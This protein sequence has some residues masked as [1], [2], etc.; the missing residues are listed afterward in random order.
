MTMSMNESHDVSGS[1]EKWTTIIRPNYGFFD[2]RI[3]ELISYRDLIYL[4]VKRDFVTKYK[5]TVLGPLWY[6]VQ[7]LISTVLFAFVFGSIA[8]IST[9]GIPYVLFYY[10][11]TM[12]W[13][14]FESCFKDASDTF[15]TN[16]SLFGKV[17]FPRLTV[18]ISRVFI[19]M[20]ALGIQFAFLA[21]FYVYYLIVGSPAHLTWLVFTI[22]LIVAWLACLGIGL[23]L[24]IT[25]ITT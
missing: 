18:P 13:T 24:I 9:D 23:G 5:Q 15:V 3:R 22:P 21:A 19:N 20:I 10:G 1:T 4:F 14:F 8:K 11:G 7:P 17:Y 25:S 12:L 6:V 2:L 16:A